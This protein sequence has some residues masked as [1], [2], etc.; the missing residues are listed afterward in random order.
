MSDLKPC[1]FCGGKPHMHH[2]GAG[3]YYVSCLECKVTSDDGTE[4]R[5]T[6]IWNRRAE[7]RE[8]R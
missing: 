3:N 7:T 5:A 6:R 8:E 4:E 2:G 1:P